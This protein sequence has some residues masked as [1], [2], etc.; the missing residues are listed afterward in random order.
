MASEFPGTSTS[1]VGPGS[2]SEKPK[3]FKDKKSFNSRKKDSDTILDQYPDKLPIIIERY[4]HEKGLPVLDKIKY[5]V[6]FEMTMGTL[7]SIIRKRLQLNSTQTLFLI[8][9]QKNV[10]CASTPLGEIYSAEKDNDGFL[11]VVYASQ[12]VFG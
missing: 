4:K 5:L 7:S 1:S 8:V 3:G 2:C 9:N 6:P 10:F 12:E 11:Y